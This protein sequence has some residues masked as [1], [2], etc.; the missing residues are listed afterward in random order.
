M[1][2]SRRCKICKAVFEVKSNSH[3]YCDFECA[4]EA[5]KI[6]NDKKWKKE[7]AVRKE[8]LKTNSDYVR[9]LQV[10]FN[11]F[12]RK[13]DEG[14]N[15]VSCNQPYKTNFQAGHFHST[16]GYP[17]LRFIETNVH[18]QCRYCNL[19]AHGNLIEYRE[20]LMKRIGGGELTILETLKNIPRKYSIPEL[21]A[22][23]IKYKEK[24]K[25]LCI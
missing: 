25:M 10:V 17:E 20:G 5:L 3:W 18:G 11:K 19:H 2:K 7:K 13:R 1:N 8:A 14:L 12:I 6:K 24:T 15:C 16:G 23:K 4:M 21:K 9:E 22:L